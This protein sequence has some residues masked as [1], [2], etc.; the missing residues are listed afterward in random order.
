MVVVGRGF[1]QDTCSRDI[2]GLSGGVVMEGEEEEV[3]EGYWKK[4][5][6]RCEPRDD[7]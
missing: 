2:L 3:E 5:S 6:E 1:A 7:D 4:K